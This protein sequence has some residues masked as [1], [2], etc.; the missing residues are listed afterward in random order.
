MT[1]VSELLGTGPGTWWA[2]G[3]YQLL[4]FFSHRAFADTWGK[5]E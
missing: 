1:F 5:N 2:L 4:F 3:Q